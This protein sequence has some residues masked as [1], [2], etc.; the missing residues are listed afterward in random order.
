MKA[1]PVIEVPGPPKILGKTF[2]KRCF[3]LAAL[4]AILVSF[5]AAGC[6][7]RIALVRVSEEDRLKA[8][9][10]VREG[11]EAYRNKDYYAALIK[12][13]SAEELN[14]NSGYISNYTGIAY[15][16]LNYYDKAIKEFTRSMALDSKYPSAVNNL[17]SAYFADGN[18]R[19][20]EKYFKKAI[21]MKKDEASFYLNLGTLYFETKKP[22]KAIL[23]WR[24]S[25]ELDPNI[26]SN[27]NSPSISISG[28]N[29]S[30]K[31]RA[32]FMARIYAAAGN[33]PKT[34]E[35]LQ[36][37]LMKGYSDIDAIKSNPDF[38]AMRGD[39]R[40]KKFM[41]DAESW[42]RRE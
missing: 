34:I 33:I 3:R 9:Q 4:L 40:F 11:N 37:A 23:E 6:G 26:L 12:Y 1:I 25:L 19:K 8:N 10:Y 32:Y 15:L 5:G 28:E 35:C 20:A 27:N 7:P 16:R 18:H 38:D 17:G 21:K 14:P 24:K 2:K 30:E 41:A 22:E 13:L 31:D 42:R 39:E 36:D 29:I